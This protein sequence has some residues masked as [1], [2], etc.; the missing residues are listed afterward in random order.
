LV[1]GTSSIDL[2]QDVNISRQGEAHR[3]AG[4]VS[5]HSILKLITMEK[6]VDD[7]TRKPKLK[8]PLILEIQS[9]DP[10]LLTA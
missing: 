3:I 5:S 8:K 10:Y 6:A 7:V 9:N 1:V 4:N 2:P